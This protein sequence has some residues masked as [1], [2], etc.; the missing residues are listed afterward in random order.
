MPTHD[1][2][3]SRVVRMPKLTPDTEA[4]DV[5]FEQG[6]IL[7]EDPT[8]PDQV[9]R[10]TVADFEERIAGLSR[11]VDLAEEKC[12]RITDAR[13]VTCGRREWKRFLNDVYDLL[14]EAKQ[15]LHVGLPPEIVSEVTESKKPISVQSG[16]GEGF[17]EAKSGLFV[18]E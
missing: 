13:V 18:P 5:W 12:S 3:K 9:C 4:V 15:Q 1:L 8:D 11:T 16:F 10:V 17:K 14:Q 6:M 7:F 2:S